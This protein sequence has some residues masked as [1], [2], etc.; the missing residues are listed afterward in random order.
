M[1]SETPV[2]SGA[3]LLHAQMGGQNWRNNTGAAMID[4]RMV[5]WGLCNDSAQLNK[6][7][8]SSD[9]IGITP[10]LIQP[11]HVGRVVGIFTALEAKHR[12]WHMIPS[13]ARACAQQAFHDIVKNVGGF[14]G[15]V[16]EP[17]DV[18][19]ICRYE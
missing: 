8:K 9:I 5:R 1:V 7:I 2:Q 3:R 16:T 14:A 12:G 19:R 6:R 17:T 11:E 18:Y 10:L 15:F 13:D 4:G